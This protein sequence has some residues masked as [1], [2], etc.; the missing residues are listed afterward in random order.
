MWA[1]EQDRNLASTMGSVF[2][3]RAAPDPERV[4]AAVR[5]AVA[6]VPRLRQHVVPATGAFSTPAWAFDPAFD[7]EHHLRHV[8]APAPGRPEQLRRLASQFVADPF[9]RT[10]PP[11]QILLV[12][13]LRGGQAALLAKL[14]HSITD[15]TG[16]LLLA[17]HLLDLEPDAPPPSPVD[18]GE[19]AEADRLAELGRNGVGVAGEQLRRGAEKALRAVSEAANAMADPVALQ[20]LGL[21]AMSRARAVAAQLPGTDRRTSPLWARR[22]RNRRLEWLALPLSA[23][24]ERAHELQVSLN[25]LFVGATV[26]GASRYHACFGVGIDELTATLI[27]STRTGAEGELANAFTPASAVLP[28]SSTMDPV[29]RVRAVSA[30]LTAQKEAARSSQ[31]AVRP[32]A[33]VLGLLPPSVA[34]GVARDQAGRVDFATSNLRG[35]PVPVWLASQPVTAVYPVGPVAGTAFNITLMS[36]LD[37]L[38]LGLNVDPVAVADP[39]LLARSVAQGFAAVGVAPLRE[40]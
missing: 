34:T 23:A 4:A 28:A 11:W 1:V 22:S 15:G 25:D 39:G 3:L 36:N 8:R 6:A 18:L 40:R 20:N 12:T 16:A 21:H 10:R 24:R 2:V 19:V 31:D 35:I 37:Q 14:H 33:A 17:Q 9:D 30:V 13:G 32:L 7:L 29:E 5:S 26:D 38:H 27:V